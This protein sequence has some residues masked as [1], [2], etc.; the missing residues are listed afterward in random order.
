MITAIKKMFEWDKWSLFVLLLNTT[1]RLI[2]GSREPA[3]H[4]AVR[5]WKTIDRLVSS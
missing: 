5:D 4:L 3:R 1:H 2:N